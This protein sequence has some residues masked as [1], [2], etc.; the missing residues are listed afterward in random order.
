VEDVVRSDDIPLL[1]LGDAL[2]AHSYADLI[3]HPIDQHPNERA[4]AIAARE[5]ERFLREHRLLEQR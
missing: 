3:V 2:R 5:L 1:H 4:H